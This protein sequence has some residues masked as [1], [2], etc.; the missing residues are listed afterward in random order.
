MRNTK[1]FVRTSVASALIMTALAPAH[2]ETLRN[3]L[4]KAYRTNPDLNAARAD[5]RANDEN[6]PLALAQGRPTSQLSGTYTEELRRTIS[7]F[8][9][10]GFSTPKRNVN[11]QATANLPIYQGGIVRNS[12]LAAKSSVQAGQENLRG[13]EASLFSA[14]VSAYMDVIRDSAVVRLNEQNVHALSVNLQ[15]SSD[16]FEVGDLT[17]TDVAQSDSRLALARASLQSAQADLIASK[18]RYVSLVGDAP[19]DLE[20]PPPLPGMPA[21]P[22][23]AVEVALKDNPNIL[24]AQHQREAAHHNSDSAAGEVMP[25]VSAFVQGSYLDYLG[26]EKDLNENFRPQGS[27]K[28]ASAGV[29]LTLPL[30][31]GGRPG[32]LTRQARARES[33]A[34]E[35]E[36]A[37]ERNVIA[38]ARSAYARWQASLL[39]IESTKTAVSSGEL[40]LEGVQAEN[41][42]GTRTILDILDSQRDLL[43]AQVQHVTAQRDAYVAGFSLLAAMGHAEARD[44]GLDGGPLYD[45]NVNYR[46][47]HHKLIDFDFGPTATKESTSTVK[48]PAQNTDLIKIGR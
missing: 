32:A 18:E 24:A 37:A 11:A 44:L 21:T 42:A 25:R 19:G 48:V 28:A 4:V 38:Q 22:E 47:V 33:S 36:I 39:T 15:A 27:N 8:P 35:Q 20:P 17:R 30:Y 23:A 7:P 9:G 31:Q 16:R 34:L 46:Q 5:Q 3:A 10:A 12:I 43:N 41:S 40:S 29:Q 13:T 45:P 26:S 6:V 1:R 2:A 14:V